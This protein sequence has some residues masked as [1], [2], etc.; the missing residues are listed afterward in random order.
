MTSRTYSRMHEFFIADDPAR[1]QAFLLSTLLGTA[2]GFVS[3][4]TGASPRWCAGI[5][6]I[7]S[8][9][10]FVGYVY[11][12]AAGEAVLDGRIQSERKAIVRIA[13]AAA[14]M[15][16]IGVF[17]GRPLEAAII[18]ERL[19]RISNNPDPKNIKAAG[20]LIAAASAEQIVLSSKPIQAIVT[21]RATLQDV[22]L[23]VAD[24]VAREAERRNLNVH[25]PIPGL[26]VQVSSGNLQMYGISGENAHFS[27]VTAAMYVPPD[28]VAF[29]CP[30]GSALEKPRLPGLGLMRLMV[31]E[32][33]TLAMNLD[34][35]HC[36][37]M[38][39]TDCSLTYS[40]GRLILENVGFYNCKL[41]FSEN[42]P[43][44][45]LAER[46][47]LDTALNLSIE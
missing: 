23:A 31:A 17:G 8:A 15:V 41:Q 24:N 1:S 32:G 22:L 19:R 35:L 4:L 33:G 26:L 44:Q 45:L 39:F 28:M 14:A 12:Y 37:N 42:L 5:A 11:Y 34:N 40:G 29:A 46:I 16:A 9:L 38:T 18:N 30:I 36:K 47:L 3:Y 13:F 2:S 7:S 20:R 43:C 27:G 6:A 21:H 10:V 25:I